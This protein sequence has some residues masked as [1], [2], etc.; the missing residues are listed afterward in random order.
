MGAGIVQCIQQP[1]AQHAAAK[2][3][4]P[5]S[6]N[7]FGDFGQAGEISWIGQDL[8]KQN[9]IESAGLSNAELVFLGSFLTLKG[10]SEPS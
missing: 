2:Q 8:P 10:N 5:K 6:A 9:F 1:H 3:H 4:C 7:D